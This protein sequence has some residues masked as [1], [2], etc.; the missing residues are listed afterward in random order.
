[1]LSDVRTM[2][3]SWKLQEP[4]QPTPSVGNTLLVSLLQARQILYMS[5][6]YLNSFHFKEI[7]CAASRMPLWYV[8]HRVPVDLISTREEEVTEMVHHFSRTEHWLKQM[9]LTGYG[10]LHCY[11]GQ[12]RRESHL[13]QHSRIAG[14][15]NASK[16]W[17]DSFVVQ[18]LHLFS[19]HRCKERCQIGS[20]TI[21]GISQKKERC[22]WVCDSLL[23]GQGAVLLRNFWASRQTASRCW[24]AESCSSPVCPACCQH[25][26]IWFFQ[27]FENNEELV[28][29]SIIIWVLGFYFCPP[30]KRDLVNSWESVRDESDM[31]GSQHE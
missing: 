19:K 8:T 2:E 26:N 9:S 12:K 13:F 15:I 10:L 21:C 22:Q 27:G 17:K 1:M 20:E 24:Q 25:S 6:S 28:W 4:Q 3:D 16:I 14:M 18:S 29:F 30:K 7:D 31:S 5:Y 23:P 11:D